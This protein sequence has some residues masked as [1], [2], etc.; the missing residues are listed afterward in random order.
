MAIDGQEVLHFPLAL[1]FAGEGHGRD[2]LSRA[3]VT[4]DL[5][6]HA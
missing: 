1:V 2:L 3:K 5:I 6:L 4:I